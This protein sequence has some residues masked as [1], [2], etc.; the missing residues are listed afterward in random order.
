MWPS[1]LLITKNNF[2]SS[3]QYDNLGNFKEKETAYYNL[4]HLLYW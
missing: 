2:S 1:I 3:K 4:L